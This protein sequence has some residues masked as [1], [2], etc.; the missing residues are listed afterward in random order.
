MPEKLGGEIRTEDRLRELLHGFS[1]K[2]FREGKRVFFIVTP[3]LE[4]WPCMALSVELADE[5]TVETLELKILRRNPFKP[6]REKSIFDAADRLRLSETGGKALLLLL[7]QANPF[8]NAQE[9]NAK[10]I[11]GLLKRQEGWLKIINNSFRP[12]GKMFPKTAVYTLVVL[13]VADYVFSPSG[14]KLGVEP[15]VGREILRSEET[16]REHSFERQI[17]E[18][19]S[20]LEYEIEGARLPPIKLGPAK[21]KK[22]S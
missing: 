9:E 14:Q 10:G 7:A 1:T 16:I 20:H 22:R 13:A 15:E 17:E 21:R 2:A 19:T 6:R 18:D 11:I 5:K 12:F 3:R 8:V 4:W